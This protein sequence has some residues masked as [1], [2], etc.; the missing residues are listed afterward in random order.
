[1]GDWFRETFGAMYIEL[2]A[3]RDD[4]EAS[5]TVDLLEGAMAL[6]PGSRVLDAPCGAG[7]H[8]REFARR[9]HAVTALD[10]S[11][12]LLR[13]AAAG[14]TRGMALVRAD[15]RA[16]PARDGAF[17]AVLN[18]FSSI[19]YFARDEDNRG[20]LRELARLCR[21]GGS[22]VVDFFNEP[23]LRR[24]LVA[25][26]RRETPAGWVVRETRAIAGTPARVEKRTVVVQKDG[27]RHE[28]FES[29]R[30]FT[31][32]ELEN[33]MQFAGVRVVRRFGGYDGSAYGPDSRRL[34]LV[35]ERT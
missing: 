8:A 26:S 31:P 32:R 22:V 19:G 23:W 35:G 27:A 28:M 9:G 25:S 14:A 1:M 3:H 20:T 5:R 29:V 24:H 12:P 10:L 17:D 34:I 2:Y 11:A 4:A 33:L 18:L 16:L 13:C 30:L 6:R 21:R 7:R 15:L